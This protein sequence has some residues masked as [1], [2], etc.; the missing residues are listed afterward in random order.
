MALIV[1]MQWMMPC[2]QANGGRSTRA[3]TVA[4]GRNML[5]LNDDN[6]LEAFAH[7]PSDDF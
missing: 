2:V 5:S 3:P 7:E 6:L 4:V 1:F